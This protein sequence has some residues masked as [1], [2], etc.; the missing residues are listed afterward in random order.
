ML[1]IDKDYII[2]NGIHIEFPYRVGNKLLYIYNGDDNDI[3]K[4]PAIDMQFKSYA[5]NGH[6]Y[7]SKYHIDYVLPLLNDIFSF[8][9]NIN[10]FVIKQNIID[11]KYDI[12][13]LY[14]LDDSNEYSVS[15]LTFPSLESI[16]GGY[17]I[18]SG[19]RF[20]VRMPNGESGYHFQ[21][22]LYH[23]SSI[24]TNYGKN[25][26]KVILII[27]DSQMIPD[28]SVLC[29]YYKHVIYIDNRNKIN[30]L[31]KIC[32]YDVDDI[33]V[34]LYYKRKECYYHLIR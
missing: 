25:N 21:Y 4:L 30:W 7:S 27:G 16:S 29:Y 13:S 1:G 17:D 24:V 18:L 33:L 12:S 31:D 15:S 14:P 28:I 2:R 20:S 19:K 26:G 5:L 10:D 9:F 22:C 8:G 32:A 6:H 11:G 3:I 23:T 34:Q